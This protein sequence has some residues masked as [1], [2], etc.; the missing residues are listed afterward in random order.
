MARVFSPFFSCCS[1][2]LL[3]LG[4]MGLLGAENIKASFGFPSRDLN[5]SCLGA[6]FTVTAAFTTRVACPSNR[7]AAFGRGGGADEDQ[8]NESKE[9]V[10]ENIHCSIVEQISDWWAKSMQNL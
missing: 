8:S 9:F 10:Q 5:A 4:I 1:L 6:E 7:L 3:A 2:D